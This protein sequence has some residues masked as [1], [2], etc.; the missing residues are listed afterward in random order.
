MC[1]PW[2]LR[3]FFVIPLKKHSM[4]S[5]FFLKFSVESSLL[6]S[7]MKYYI[8][9]I[10]SGSS[11]KLKCRIYEPFFWIK[12]EC[13][14]QSFFSFL[15]IRSHVSF[16]FIFFFSKSCPP[17]QHSFT[18]I[19]YWF[20]HFWQECSSSQQKT[21]HWKRNFW[22]IRFKSDGNIKMLSSKNAIARVKTDLV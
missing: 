16:L 15:F 8:W 9:L 4:K 7:T 22:Y 1:I 12:I 20:L 19:V 10:G 5:R 3:P 14:K 18:K 11:T 17:Q 2:V 13:M 21:F 6:E